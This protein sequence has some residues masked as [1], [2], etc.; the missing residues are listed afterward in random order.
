MSARARDLAFHA[1]AGA[2]KD[3]EPDARIKHRAWIIAQTSQDDCSTQSH[4]SASMRAYMCAFDKYLCV[5]ICILAHTNGSITGKRSI[6]DFAN[7]PPPRN[8]GNEHAHKRTP[9]HPPSPVENSP[10]VHPHFGARLSI[11]VDAQLLEGVRVEADAMA[12]AS[13]TLASEISRQ[14]MTLWCNCCCATAMQQRSSSDATKKQQRCNK[15]ATA[16]PK[17]L[18]QQSLRS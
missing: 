12:S 18:T 8:F 6:D 14:T 9:R 10:P 17:V 11:N 2:A 3:S 16:M 1:K 5:S 13:Y 4:S 15:E 7:C